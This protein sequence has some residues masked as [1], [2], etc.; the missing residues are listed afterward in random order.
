MT[1]KD[2]YTKTD[3]A[4]SGKFTDNRVAGLVGSPAESGDGSEYGNLALIAGYRQYIFNDFNLISCSLKM[5][6]D[7]PIGKIRSG[8]KIHQQPAPLCQ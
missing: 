3:I 2:L 7:S 8:P 6:A 5:G 1:K 4:V